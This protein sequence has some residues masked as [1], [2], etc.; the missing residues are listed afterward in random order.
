MMNTFTRSI[1]TVGLGLVG[2]GTGVS[3]DPVAHPDAANAVGECPNPEGP[4]HPYTDKAELEALLV[5]K[6]RHCSGPTMTGPTEAGVELVADHSYFRLVTD[7]QGGLMRQTGPGNQGTWEV[8]ETLSLLYHP[9]PDLTG[10]GSP[11]FEDGPRKMG[12]FLAVP[13]LSI[14]AL[15]P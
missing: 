2:C 4:Q 8:D 5:G 12:I 6:W 3:G 9:R 10:N 1:A 15:E 14:Y 13:D 11:R 7:D